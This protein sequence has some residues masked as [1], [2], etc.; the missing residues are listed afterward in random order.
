M[1]TNTDAVRSRYCLALADVIVT[2][3]AVTMHTHTAV[4]DCSGRRVWGAKGRRVWVAHAI[5]QW[6][7]GRCSG[8]F[9]MTHDE[10]VLD[11]AH[12]RLRRSAAEIDAVDV[13]SHHL[14]QPIKNVT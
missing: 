10:E 9:E 11:V 5:G 7:H 8:R 6:L 2:I 13:A 1:C 3:D 12:F 4:R 14:C